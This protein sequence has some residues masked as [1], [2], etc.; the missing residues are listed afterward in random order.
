MRPLVVPR[1]R[2]SN[3]TARAALSAR[4]SSGGA[5]LAP[6]SVLDVTMQV[7]DVFGLFS[8]SPIAFDESA[9]FC[10][11]C[12]IP[13]RQVGRLDTLDIR[14]Y[15]EL[16]HGKPQYPLET[17]V[18]KSYRAIAAKLRIDEDTVRNRVARMQ[19][20]GI[21]AGWYVLPNPS[22]MGLSICQLWMELPSAQ[23]KREAI[24]KLKLIP[25]IQA[26]HDCYGDVLW[27]YV[28]GEGDSA[29]QRQVDLI[30][31]IVAARDVVTGEMDWPPCSL[32]LTT[33]D[34]RI[35][36]SLRR[37]PRSSYTA[38][39][40]DLG[41]SPRTVRRRLE[42]MITAGALFLIPLFRPRR[43]RGNVLTN[44]AVFCDAGVT[45]VTISKVVSRVE[46]FLLGVEAYEKSASFHLLLDN[47]S[48]IEEIL[49]WARSL[50]GVTHARLDILLDRIELVDHLDAQLERA[51][52]ALS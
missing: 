18:R 28:M 48:E 14:I 4:S 5:P 51:L 22:L 24:E 20:S 13:R 3:K 16:V 39:S 10:P 41:F 21:L 35:V 7:Q 8:A 25:S 1:A 47:I 29:L 38:V 40:K 11:R 30:R 50:E 17:D 37:N 26:I 6:D 36:Q 34:W 32:R 31:G 23:S 12:P 33:R 19:R 52:A 46:E 9:D 2:L 44:L 45:K 42:R 27:V 43:L 49:G 15:R